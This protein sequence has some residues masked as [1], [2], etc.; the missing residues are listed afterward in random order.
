[1]GSGNNYIQEN[2]DPSD[3]ERTLRLDNYYIID[4]FGM[5]SLYDLNVKTDGVGDEYKK[6]P[7]GD[8]GRYFRRLKIYKTKDS[9]GD[10]DIFEVGFRM[11]VKSA[12]DN[13]KISIHRLLILALWNPAELCI[14]LLTRCVHQ[15]RNNFLCAE[16]SVGV[17]LDVLGYNDSFSFQSHHDRSQFVKRMFAPSSFC[18]AQGKPMPRRKRCT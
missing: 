5:P 12:T 3:F 18:E 6:L 2:R 9:N 13:H 17:L 8:T 7:L 11:F 4:Q 1:M 16:R 14:F 15:T 10:I